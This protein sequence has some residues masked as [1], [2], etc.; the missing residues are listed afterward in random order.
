MHFQWGCQLSIFKPMMP[1]IFGHYFFLLQCLLNFLALITRLLGS[2]TGG[3]V[4][5]W[6]RRL[7]YL[8]CMELHSN[9]QV[10]INSIQIDVEDRVNVC[11]T[12]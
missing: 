11:S 4:R 10:P 9:V 1:C 2:N 3:S 8:P 6:D 12:H 7:G 5:M